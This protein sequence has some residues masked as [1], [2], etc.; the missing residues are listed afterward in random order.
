MREG[1]KGRWLELILALGAWIIAW[2]EGDWA[3]GMRPYTFTPLR[4]GCI[5][6]G[7]LPFGLECVAA[8]TAVLGP[9]PALLYG[10]V[11]RR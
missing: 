11:L 2:S 1:A 4:L 10:L 5:G 8:A 9:R 7:C 3:R 6:A